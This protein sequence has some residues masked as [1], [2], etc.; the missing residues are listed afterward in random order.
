MIGTAQQVLEAPSGNRLERALARVGIRDDVARLLA[1]TPSLRLSWLAAGIATIASASWAARTGDAEALSLFLIVAPLL[2]VA[3]VAAAYGPWA[4]PM[5]EIT[6][7]A[8]LSSF[9]VLL[10]RS[11]AVL[12]VATTIAGLGSL[13]LPGPSW[14]TLAWILPSFG[15]TVASLALAT[16]M[17]IHRA[18]G[19]V[20]LLWF[21][22]LIVAGFVS[23][24]RLATFRGPGQ[25]AFFVLAVGSS[26]VLA[27]RREHVEMR[28]RERRRAL[29]DV[30]ETERRRIERNIHD[31]AQQQLV[32]ISVK[33]GLARS[34]VSTDPKRAEALLETL[35][36]ETQEALD[37]L[38][39]MTR[40]TY[41]PILA[42]EGIPAAV[43]ARARKASM[44]VVVEAAGIGRFDK[45]IET[46]VYY[47][48]LE[49]IQNAS[50]YASATRVVV[51]LHCVGGELS[52]SISDDGLGFD[53]DTAGRGVGLRSMSERV[54]ALGGTL[55]VRS[56]PDAG[57]TISGRIPLT[58]PAGSG[59]WGGR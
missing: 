52:F 11:T 42:D 38:R 9:R 35:Q 6:Q 51:G 44:P 36:A 32:A 19:V 43:D 45:Q 16:F 25:T 40:G 12:A 54:E 27:W 39:E 48:C 30:A 15:L 5:F 17:P 7:A 59:S 4:D 14:T 3:A 41:P 50:K 10:L 46:A 57:T 58:R 21:G 29:I 20:V 23:D 18:S 28:G 26:G 31:G 13:V 2:P 37:A 22:S 8:P 24:D 33:L 34:F 49:A 1:A 56:A 55:E 47:C 53:V